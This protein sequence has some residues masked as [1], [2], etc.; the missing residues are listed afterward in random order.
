MKRR[1]WG[2]GE[3]LMPLWSGTFFHN[4]VSVWVFAQSEAACLIYRQFYPPV[5]SELCWVVRYSRV[6]RPRGSEIQRRE[7]MK[8]LD[9]PR[10]FHAESPVS[11]SEDSAS[12]Q[13]S[14]VWGLSWVDS[15]RVIL[16]GRI[17]PSS[18]GVVA[19]TQHYTTTYSGFISHAGGLSLIWPHLRFQDEKWFSVLHDKKNLF[20][21]QG[22][23]RLPSFHKP[24]QT[25]FL[26][27]TS[28]LSFTGTVGYLCD[29]N[30]C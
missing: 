16:G 30:V 11:V 14:S 27:I 5:K 18:V 10:L 8:S 25:G 6:L 4:S 19:V 24:G 23:V 20:S 15:W 3:T 21:V 22:A 9:K 28:Q 17:F 1:V 2:G 26:T 12:L 13:R 7:V 29:S